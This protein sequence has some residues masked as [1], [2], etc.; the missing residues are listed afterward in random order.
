MKSPF[1][2]KTGS[3]QGK[4]ELFGGMRWQFPLWSSFFSLSIQ[5]GVNLVTQVLR[6]WN[7]NSFRVKLIL[8][9]HRPP[10]KQKCA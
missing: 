6:L 7:C 10:L 1:G 5:K 2:L 4:S 3:L 8:R 9:I